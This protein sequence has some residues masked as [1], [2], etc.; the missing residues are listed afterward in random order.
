MIG[1]KAATFFLTAAVTAAALTQ[2]T[3]AG[4]ATRFDGSWSLAVY[5]RTGPCDASYRFSGQIVNGTIAYSGV[6]SVA[7]AGRVRSTGAVWLRVSSGA[8]YATASGR[9]KIQT[10]NGI[11][12][13]QSSDGH[14]TGTWTATRE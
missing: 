9:L 8:G 10:G 13:G 1:Q 4:A 6:G 7:I 3:D 12:R 5:T 14:C 2:A 11:W